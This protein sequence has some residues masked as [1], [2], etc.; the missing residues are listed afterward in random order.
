MKD[1]GTNAKLDKKGAVSGIRSSWL[2]LNEVSL[3]SFEKLCFEILTLVDAPD[4]ISSTSLKLAAVL[5]LEVLAN[6]FPTHDKVFSMCLG[7]VC[8]RICSNNFSLSSN[9]LRTAGALVNALGPRALPELPSLMEC[10]LRKSHDVSTADEETKR[11][12]GATGSSNSVHSLYMSILLTLEAVV[13]NLAG[14]LNPYLGDILRLVVL[15]PLSFSTSDLKLKLKADVVRKLI[16]EKIS[17]SR[18]T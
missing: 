8:R 10:L 15:H 13:N 7:S 14:F 11:G 5:S 17:V 6:R 18:F 4:D 3:E 9:C 16:T 1:L 12:V 2:Q